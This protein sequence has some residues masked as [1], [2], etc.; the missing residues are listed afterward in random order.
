[1]NII[2]PVHD[3]TMILSSH[4]NTIILSS[5]Y[6]IKNNTIILNDDNNILK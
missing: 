2:Y 4:D 3:N 1:M 6:S 5:F